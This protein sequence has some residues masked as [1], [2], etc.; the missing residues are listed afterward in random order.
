MR[1]DE[2]GKRGRQHRAFRRIERVV[3]ADAQQQ[4]RA[5]SQ[6]VANARLPLRYV[7]VALAAAQH[8]GR[9][10]QFHHAGAFSQHR[11]LPLRHRRQAA[12]Q[13]QHGC[14]SWL[15][16]R[17]DGVCSRRAR[18]EQTF[19]ARD[20]AREPARADPKQ[21]V[22][23][24][25]S[26]PC[27]CDQV[28]LR[29]GV[30]HQRLGAARRHGGDSRDERLAAFA[31]CVHVEL[32]GRNTGLREH[33]VQVCGAAR[34]F[35][36][37]GIGGFERLAAHEDTAAEYGAARRRK[38]RRDDRK[39]RERLQR[40]D[41]GGPIAAQ[42]RVDLLVETPARFAQRPPRGRRALR[43]LGRRET[44]GVGIGCDHVGGA[45]VEALRRH[46]E[47]DDRPIAGVGKADRAI[48]GARQ[49]VRDDQHAHC[50]I[51]VASRPTCTRFATAAVRI[52][53]RTAVTTTHAA[54]SS[55]ALLA[56]SA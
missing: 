42:R 3:A 52:G 15:P 43:G 14:V 1:L 48:G 9:Y 27:E 54:T 11:A 18:G 2:R 34:V 49:I 6:R 25:C 19:H 53:E 12:H 5:R 38:R 51:S 50:A 36:L 37:P 16:L 33:R 20:F 35:E 8:G 40:G 47:R 7:R 30:D 45:R 24:L 29:L 31:Q 41:F 13:H 26:R 17:S 28:V 10:R 56:A 46:V 39:T 22:V 55:V 32:G 44:A 21:R 4:V 23:H